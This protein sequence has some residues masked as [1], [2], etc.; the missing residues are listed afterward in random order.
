MNFSSHQRKLIEKI[1]Q[2]LNKP[3]EALVSEFSEILKS[4]RSLYKTD[5]YDFWLGIIETVE[6]DE[7]PI[8]NHGHVEALNRFKDMYGCGRHS[9][10]R[11]ID[12]ICE[13]LFTYSHPDD[14]CE[15]QSQFHTYFSVSKNTM[16][17][18]S[19]L[20]VTEG[21]EVNDIGESRIAYRSEINASAKEF[22]V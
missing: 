19:E 6:L 11:S 10:E 16:Y 14:F 9:V 3:K 22:Y 4:A 12:Y 5:E 7:I 1:E 17:K 15:M 13:K 21:I 18:V 2:A 20:G 8:T